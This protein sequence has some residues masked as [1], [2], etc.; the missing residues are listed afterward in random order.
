MDPLNVVIKL[1]H[2]RRIFIEMI[3]FIIKDGYNS[4]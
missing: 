4:E 2:S 3:M 1:Q